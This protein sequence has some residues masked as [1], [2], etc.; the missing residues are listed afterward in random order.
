[1]LNEQLRGLIEQTLDKYLNTE[2]I[3]AVEFLAKEYAV[4][5]IKD[6]AIGFVSGA[7]K[8]TA[9]TFALSEMK[10]FTDEEKAEINTIVKRRLPEFL[11]KIERELAK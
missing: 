10:S 9:V 8:A 5:S 6:L 4:S 2:L 11:K 1:M 7:A 3:T